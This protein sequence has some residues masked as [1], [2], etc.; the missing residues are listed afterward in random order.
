[1]YDTHMTDHVWKW[2]LQQAA[3]QKNG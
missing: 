2:M 1:L 3:N